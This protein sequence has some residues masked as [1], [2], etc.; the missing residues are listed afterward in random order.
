[1][2]FDGNSKIPFPDF[3][4]L[5]SR[6]AEA[7]PGPIAFG[8]KYMTGG[9]GEGT[10]QLRPESNFEEREQVK[11]D[12]VLPAYCDP[13][14]PCPVGYSG[15][16]GCLEEFDNTAEFSKAYQES[17]T[18][19]CD[20]EHMFS[21]PGKGFEDLEENIQKM[22]DQNGFHKN[23]IAKKFHEKRENFMEPRRKRSLYFDMNGMHKLE[24]PYLRGEVLKTVSKK[25]GRNIR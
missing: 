21:C 4:D 9:A 20:H 22:L 12:N 19:A 16:D 5:I 23:L 8:H 17:Q 24:N 14:N 15:A 6:D 3:V 7:L 13:P 18:C 25:D 1:M 2:C 10:Q 11:S